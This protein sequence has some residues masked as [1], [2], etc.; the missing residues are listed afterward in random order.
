LEILKEKNVKASF[1]ASAKAIVAAGHE[2][3]NHTYGHINF[4]VYKNK[5]KTD[6]MEKELL[7]SRNIIKDATGVEPF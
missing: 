2:I 5:D 7:H 6:K 3:V 1:Y 4:Y